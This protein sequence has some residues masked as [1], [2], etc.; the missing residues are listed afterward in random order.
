MAING[1]MYLFGGNTAAHIHTAFNDLWRID[2]S[3]LD[4]PRPREGYRLQWEHIE[5]VDHPP[6]G[7]GHTSMKVGDNL[8]LYGGRDL[9]RD[10][11]TPNVYLFDV[12]A[13]RWKML[14]TSD[15]FSDR[16][17]HCAILCSSG[18]IFFGGLKQASP[19]ATIGSRYSNELILVNL[20]GVFSEES[21]ECPSTLSSTGPRNSS[22]P[23]S[24]VGGDFQSISSALSDLTSPRRLTNVA[25]VFKI[26]EA[27]DQRAEE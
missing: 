2:L 1:Y 13:K 6:A 22:H 8:V 11:F 15:S 16:T 17:G 5:T 10:A 18:I 19:K 12:S 26:E 24:Y 4:D 3:C 9:F 21:S 7:I 23:E 27:I 25:G 20:F 14:I